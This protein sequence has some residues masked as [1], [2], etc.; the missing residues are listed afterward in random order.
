[1]PVRVVFGAGKHGQGSIPPVQLL[2]ATEQSSLSLGHRRL[3]LE[4]GTPTTEQRSLMPEHS[5]KTH[6]QAL[7]RPEQTL[8]K[9]GHS[10]L[11]LIPIK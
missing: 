3:M 2:L 8:L 1:M 9:L 7:L 10:R 4:Q 6:G 5:R 11:L